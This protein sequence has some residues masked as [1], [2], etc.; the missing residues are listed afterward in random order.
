MIYIK[1]EGFQYGNVCQPGAAG[2]D[3][4]HEAKDKRQEKTKKERKREKGPLTAEPCF[5]A[6]RKRGI[7]QKILHQSERLSYCYPPLSHLYLDITKSQSII[8]RT[9]YSNKY[10]PKY[11]FYKPG[12]RDL[13]H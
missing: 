13:D 4:S 6:R 2:F 3:F 12:R 9:K 7:V 11:C 5:G 1:P 8:R 10:G